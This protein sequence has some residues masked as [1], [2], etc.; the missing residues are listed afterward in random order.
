MLSLNLVR[1]NGI[2]SSS[3]LKKKKAT[4]PLRRLIFNKSKAGTINCKASKNEDFLKDAEIRGSYSAIFGVMSA[5]LG[6]IAIDTYID[7]HSQ[8]AGI[9]HQ[10]ALE[11]HTT[12]FIAYFVIVFII[13]H[14]VERMSHYLPET[15]LSDGEERN[16]NSLKSYDNKEKDIELFLGRMCMILFL[17]FFINGIHNHGFA[18]E[19]GPIQQV[20]EFLQSFSVMRLGM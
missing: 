16:K 14:D 19:A 11:L 5:C 18:N 4:L 8:S 12:P 13:A 3:K 2:H 10:V 17:Y 9:V 7:D 1:Q 15:I 20:Q 6:E